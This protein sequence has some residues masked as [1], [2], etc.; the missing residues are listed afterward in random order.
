[1][2]DLCSNLKSTCFIKPPANAVV[3][4]Y[5]QYVH[6]LG[7]VLDRHTP[8]VSR[9]TKK[10]SAAWWSDSYWRAKSLRC[11]FEQTWRRSKNPLTLLT[12]ISQTIIVN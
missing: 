5:K 7:D 3:D 6:D 1:M 2:S 10:D 11:Q 8:L 9:L 4:L 12:R